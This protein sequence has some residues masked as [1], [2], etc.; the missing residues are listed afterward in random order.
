[1][2]YMRCTVHQVGEIH[3]IATLYEKARPSNLMIHLICLASINHLLIHRQN[4]VDNGDRS[5]N[6]FIQPVQIMMRLCNAEIL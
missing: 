2:L 1:M 5:I 6:Y 4:I 3:R